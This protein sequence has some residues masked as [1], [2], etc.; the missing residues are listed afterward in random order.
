VF[1]VSCA[2]IT[3]R[4]ELYLSVIFPVLAQ[5]ST[6]TSLKLTKPFPSK[7]TL[8]SLV[9]HQIEPILSCVLLKFSF[10]WCF[11]LSM[12]VC[13]LYVCLHPLIDASRV[14]VVQEVL[15]SKR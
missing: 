3:N 15:K 11:V 14:N 4:I 1:S 7:H 9:I 2:C 13:L 5:S 6:T 10:N 8:C 12:L